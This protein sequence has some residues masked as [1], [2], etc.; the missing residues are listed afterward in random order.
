MREKLDIDSFI[1]KLLPI[2]D[3][4]EI[5]HRLNANLR[6]YPLEGNLEDVDLKAENTIAEQT[7]F[8]GSVKGTLLEVIDK[9]TLTG[10]WSNLYV[11]DSSTSFEDGRIVGDGVILPID[12]GLLPRNKALIQQ[13]I[14]AHGSGVGMLDMK[15]NKATKSQT[16]PLSK[17]MLA[18]LE[19]AY[20]QFDGIL[21]VSISKKTFL[22]IVNDNP[23]GE[24]LEYVSAGFLYHIFDGIC[25][26]NNFRG[27]VGYIENRINT[28]RQAWDRITNSG[29]S[30]NPE[31]LQKIDTFI[32]QGR[33][34]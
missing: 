13:W 30:N 11:D 32:K 9:N 25:D 16:S 19:N 7:E 15:N 12:K 18:E 17:P 34:K 20:K 29:K 2:E 24:K 26:N 5:H 22:E 3:K 10:R 21:W 6:T 23:K 28:T 31:L 8:V 33:K 4:V 14:D 1:A 27:K